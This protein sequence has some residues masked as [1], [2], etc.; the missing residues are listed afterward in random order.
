MTSRYEKTLEKALLIH[1]Q[2]LLGMA[3]VAF[4]AEIVFY[5]VLTAQGTMES[6]PSRY[7]LKYV[8]LPTGLNG[9]C[10]LTAWLTY[11]SNGTNL[12]QKEYTVSLLAVAEAFI[13][14]IVHATFPSV[15]LLFA[16]MIIVTV[17]YGDKLLTTIIFFA[18][19]IGRCLSAIYCI[20]QSV[21]FCADELA[22]LLLA[23]IIL[24]GIYVLSLTIIR[25]ENEKREMMVRSIEEWGRMKET[26]Q[27]D[28]MTKL[29]N[30]RALED[31]QKKVQEKKLGRLPTFFAM[32]DIDG[33]KEINDTYG[34]LEGD[35][36]LRFLGE[37][38]LEPACGMLCF[39]YGG[40]EFSAFLFDD[41]WE[42][43]Q[44]RLKLLQEQLRQYTISSTGEKLLLSIS[45]GATPYTSDV[46]LSELIAR[47]DKAL[48]QVKKKDKGSIRFIQ[49]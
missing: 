48:Y 8:A 30:V 47:A 16:F 42:D 21:S 39:R 6:E 35:A 11:R 33:F 25:L 45:I 1:M 19:L 44:K 18:A 20:D 22:D 7:F 9:I 27:K 34:H 15:Y 2:T 4:A 14:A 24:C 13:I 49:Y 38:C 12:K 32:W 40:D 28:P 26:A 23:V 3:V 43:G 10:V 41:K 37:R 17:F 46:E 29:Y 5:F 36:V 31:F